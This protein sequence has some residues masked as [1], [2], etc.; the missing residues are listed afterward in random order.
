MDTVVAKRAYICH[1]RIGQGLVRLAFLHR[2]FVKS[3]ET[4]GI[5]KIQRSLT[6]TVEHQSIANGLNASAG[7]I[8]IKPCAEMDAALGIIIVLLGTDLLVV[9]IVRIGMPCSVSIH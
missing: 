8:C 7:N 9:K 6:D 3:V 2:I 1:V 5:D 4:G